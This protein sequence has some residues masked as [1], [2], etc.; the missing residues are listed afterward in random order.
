[1][2]VKYHCV[3]LVSALALCGL[4]G[5]CQKHE[6]TRVKLEV[7]IDDNGKIYRGSSIQQY[8]CRQST[9]IMSDSANCYITGEAVVVK[10]GEKG[11]LF[12]VFDK[13]GARSST[14]MVWSVLGAVSDSP[15]TATN[16]TL[17][18]SWTL[19]PDQMP[20][21][22]RFRDPSDAYSVEAVDPVHF[23]ASFG[24]GV[25]LVSVSV[26]TTDE[27]IQYGIVERELPWIYSNPSPFQVWPSRQ[28]INRLAETLGYTSFIVRK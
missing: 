25:A 3:T 27:P 23:D 16:S 26:E 12:M 5:G 8:A 13:P 10:I 22:V 9:H 15:M 11:D 19:R 24:K 1:M 28:P 21:M 17:P 18:K 14:E 6:H 2:S 4:M 20:L 7:V